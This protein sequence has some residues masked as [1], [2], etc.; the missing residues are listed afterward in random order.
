MPSRTR[1]TA[2]IGELNKKYPDTP[3]K[4][5]HAIKLLEGD[6]E[7]SEKYPVELPAVLD[8]SYEADIIN[9]KYDFIGEI[10]HEVMIHKQRQD[11]FTDKLDRA[12]THKI[13]GIPIFLG[14]MALVFFLTFYVGDAIK[15]LFELGLG[16]LS[17]TAQS[18]LTSIGA[19]EI[20]VS[21]L[22]D[23]IIGG[24]GTILTFPA[25]HLHPLPRARLPRG[26]RLHGARCLRHG[27]RHEQA[28]AL[29][30][31]VHPHALGLRLYGA[32]HHGVPRA[33]K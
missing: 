24:V 1:S 16:W 10:I 5:W 27:G 15:A 31:G 21:L 32:R 18:G 6:K 23:G 26:Q 14:I 9:Q 20:V 8:R 2:I 12:F 30:Q 33:R 19:H 25:Q 7:I 3:N 22:V 28:R 4:R 17:D 11:I 13:W 29:G